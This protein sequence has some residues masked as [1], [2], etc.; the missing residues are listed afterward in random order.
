M[1]VTL[2]F[3]SFKG[4]LS[5]GEVADAFEAGLLSCV[6][7]CEVCKVVIA[8]GGEGTTEAL[9]DVLHG[10]YIDTTVSDP[11]GRAITARYGIVDNGNTAIIEMAKASGLPLLRNDERN[12]LLTSTYGTGQM[13]VDALN[14]GCRRFLIGI[15]GSAT[16]DGHLFHFVVSFIFRFL[17]QLLASVV[18]H[19]S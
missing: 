9:V 5:S 18:S 8:D 15:G 13:I 16:N 1:K 17:C 19:Q 4:S 7:E 10:T 12:P 2:A 14:R 6:P 11:I 3:D